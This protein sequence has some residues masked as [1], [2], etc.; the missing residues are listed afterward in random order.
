MSEA[1]ISEVDQVRAI[2]TVNEEPCRSTGFFQ[3]PLSQVETLS[4]DE[5]ISMQSAEIKEATEN[6]AL[7]NVIQ[8]PVLSVLTLSAEEK[9]LTAAEIKYGTL[10]IAAHVEAQQLIHEG[11]TLSIGDNLHFTVGKEE[12]ES[13]FVVQ[14]QLQQSLADVE[15]IETEE[16]TLESVSIQESS[17]NLEPNIEIQQ[18][19][20]DVVGFT[21]T[22]K[23]LQFAGVK[24]DIREPLQMETQQPL[25]LEG[26]LESFDKISSLASVGEATPQLA[27]NVQVQEALSN[28]V[29]LNI[30]KEVTD[31]AS[32]HDESYL[33]V[34]L[35]VE[36]Q[37]TL[38][39][40]ESISSERHTEKHTKEMSI[41]EPFNR[42]AV[43][44]E[45]LK[46][47]SVADE[48]QAI[49]E[50]LTAK[51]S[52]EPT[53][54]ELAHSEIQQVL[55]FAKNIESIKESLQAKS[56]DEPQLHMIT[57]S[58]LVEVL[59]ACESSVLVKKLLEVKSVELP[60][61]KKVIETEIKQILSSCLSLQ[62]IKEAIM[63]Q[64]VP[65]KDNLA[66]SGKR[67]H[68]VA[69]EILD[70]GSDAAAISKAQHSN[71]TLDSGSKEQVPSDTAQTNVDKANTTIEYPSLQ[72]DLQEFIC[73]AEN[74]TKITET[75][76]AKL[77]THPDLK[78]GAQQEIQQMLLHIAY[79]YAIAAC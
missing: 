52:C 68:E 67:H 45:I 3:Q 33:E 19:L 23:T 47:M 39:N 78:K 2:P 53:L 12:T 54:H 18:T 13:N 28:V 25:V 41:E 36:Y 64:V 62:N 40:L 63:D 48:V 69:E 75:L 61:V 56:V 38:S 49:K 22:E 26:I 70:A 10:N 50:E 5:T 17:F 31:I 30:S 65:E 27:A 79:C 7:H 60:E 35:Q 29:D 4:T 66:E 20:S 74:M 21:E 55:A 42:V 8:E 76:Q 32:L 1:E 9:T 46:F 71:Q 51:V 59:N 24:N 37:Q 11:E 57:Q 73:V 58:E 77:S 44:S 14:G 34:A 43:Q 72:A 16:D 15:S 6:V